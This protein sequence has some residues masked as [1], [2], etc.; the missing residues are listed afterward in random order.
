MKHIFSCYSIHILIWTASYCP[1]LPSLLPATGLLSNAMIQCFS[2]E[3]SIVALTSG[4]VSGA[5]GP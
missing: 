2:F 4:V 1:V 3:K 5:Q